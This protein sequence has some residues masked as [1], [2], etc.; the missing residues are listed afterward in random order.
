M[1]ELTELINAYS[2]ALKEYNLLMS[3]EADAV[4]RQ[5][6]SWGEERNEMALGDNMEY[7]L[8]L[9][10]DCGMASKIQ[11]VY[12]DPPFYTKEKFMSSIKL[13]SE[14]LGDSKVLKIGAYDDHISESLEVYLKNLAIRMMLI[15][16]L[17]KDSGTVWVHL[18]RRVTHYARILM[19]LVFGAD[20]FVNEIIWTYK[21]GGASKKTF[22][23]KH[24]NIL[25][26]SKTDQYKFNILQEKSY[27]RGFKPYRFKGV[28]EYCDEVG[29]YTLVNMKD[30]WQLDMVGR[31]SAERSGYAT[32]K[33]EKLVERII[34]SCS[35][36]GDIC[37]DFYA[38]SGT[39]GAVCARLGRGWI[40]CDNNPAALVC[41]MERLNKD[42]DGFVVKASGD[43]PEGKA[44]MSGDL[45]TG[46]E[47]D[48][49]NV[50]CS[51]MEQLRKFMTEDGPCFIRITKRVSDE[52]GRRVYGYDILGNRFEQVIE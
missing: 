41:Q 49:E 50:T 18:D 52:T 31:T 1:K 20:N 15:R 25:V 48:L 38:G 7:M 26:Y 33:P 47:A 37:A 40:L 30:V 19:D 2:E 14:I 23:R 5:M 51:D 21:S 10:K 22:A 3:G 8:H 43:W 39:L 16:T 44:E 6:D 35:D 4:F 27:N 46:Y 11:V 29:W 12:I 45:I 34:E 36:P 32:Q 9:I 17:L 13:H 28:K 42:E 24:D